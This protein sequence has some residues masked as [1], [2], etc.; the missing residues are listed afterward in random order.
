MDKPFPTPAG[1]LPTLHR[2][3]G[4]RPFVVIDAFNLALEKGTGV[5]TYARN[6]SFNL[7]E[8]GCEVGVLHGG[9]FDASLPAL[10]QEI[11]F[12][13]GRE[14]GASR[15][16]RLRRVARVALATPWN[17]AFQV[18]MTGK[19]LS[20]TF[21]ASRP[22]YDSIWNAKDLYTKAHAQF[23]L[24]GLTQRVDLP[25]K[26]DLV[27]WTYPLPVRMPGV[28]NVYTL[29]DLVP[30]RLPYTTLDRKD[31]Y[32]RMVQWI[33]LTADHI[34]TVSEHSRRDIMEILGV[35]PERVTNTYQAVDI[36]A[37]YRDKS[38]DELERG[39]RHTF[40][41]APQGYFLFFGSIEPKKNIHRMIEGY[42]ASGVETP[43]VI[44]GAQAWKAEQELRLLKTAEMGA[45]DGRRRIVRLE[46]V[47]FSM[48][49]D[50]IRGSR[51]VL[52]PSLYEGF[53]LPVLEAMLLGV[54]VLA[55]NVSSIPEV[56]G[57]AALLVDPYETRAIADAI[58]K[59]DADPA[60]RLR[61]SRAGEK[62]AALFDG[63]AYG[64]RL[65]A[66]YETVM[67][68]QRG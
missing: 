13:D 56:A 42:L 59:L 43:L 11:A 6:L 52:F 49:V 4:G 53:G 51:G 55:S 64:R 34:V 41:L 27:H 47:P 26:P 38:Q 28:R 33:A 65:A 66:V 15:L 3:D 23:E 31:R 20:D 16:A 44:V 12:Y 1:P 62:Q 5:A 9:A 17:K 7:R 25:R 63:A 18:P 48:L 2:A 45:K 37:K 54:P 61:M 14:R 32:L 50:L 68:Q 36:P 30:L 29:H 24:L 40:G 67:G 19:V 58:R 60:L 8:L 10:L 22:F 21:A 57:D 39:L 35:P 46:Y